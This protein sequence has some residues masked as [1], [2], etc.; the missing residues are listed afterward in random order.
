MTGWTEITCQRGHDK[1]DALT[2]DVDLSRPHGFH[3]LPPI[4]AGLAP[5]PFLMRVF[6]WE[7]YGPGPYCPARDVVSEAVATLGVWEPAE[8]ILTLQVCKGQ[9]GWVLDM[10]A[11]IGWFSLLAL[12]SGMRVYAVDADP[13]P[14]A[15]LEESA[16]INAWS[17]RL[18]DHVERIG[19]ATEPYDPAWR[20][21]LAK[22]DVEGAE[23][24][25]VRMLMPLL[26]RGRIDHLLI[27]VSPVFASYYPAMLQD[28]MD[29]SYVGYL[30]PDKSIPPAVLEDPERDLTRLG[31]R[32][33]EGVADWHQRNVWFRHRGADW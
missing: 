23:D 8:T 32:D 10:G 4:P 24:E 11:Q 6:D 2:V 3:D 26:R 21:R 29:L 9:R 7:D 5:P 30:L 19:P 31:Y 33:L 25:A 17:D 1:H 18:T 27:E 16:T 13:A 14:L 15:L 12:A 22:V 20:L 28:L